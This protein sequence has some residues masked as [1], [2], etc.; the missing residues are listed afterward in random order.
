MN[1]TPVLVGIIVALFIVIG[2]RIRSYINMK[3][4]NKKAK[5]YYT[6]MAK[7]FGHL[8]G[9]FMKEK[10]ILIDRVR[11]LEDGVSET[12]GVKIR[13]D[14]TKVECVFN[15]VEMAFL[16]AGVQL[17]INQAKVI[18]D[19]EYYISLYKK[20]SKYITDMEEEQPEDGGN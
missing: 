19:Q 10:S 11:E 14:V 4:E 17:L 7:T 12:F 5:E 1:I 13:N 6:E 18:T 15:K 3:I 9:K 20:I 2:T 16:M 8:E